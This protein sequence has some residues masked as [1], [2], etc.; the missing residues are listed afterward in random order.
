MNKVH[1]RGV[2]SARFFWVACSFREV[3]LHGHG[4]VAGT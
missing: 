3:N 2:I 1:L 4:D